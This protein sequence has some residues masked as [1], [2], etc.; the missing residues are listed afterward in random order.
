MDHNPH[1]ARKRQA[2]DDK[3]TEAGIEIPDRV[4]N[5]P[6][7]TRAAEPTPAESAFTDALQ[8]IFADEVYDLPEIVVRLNRMG[9]AAP[10]GASTWTE[11]A[12]RAELAR[13][14]A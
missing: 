8:T 14:G 9:V 10:D 2:N 11:A 4:Q 7:Q 5:I 13:L 6:W 12:F 3:G 1:L